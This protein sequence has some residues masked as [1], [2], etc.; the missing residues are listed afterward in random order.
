MFG[1]L[2]LKKVV[3]L[4][5]QTLYQ[6][7]WF[8]LFHQGSKCSVSSSSQSP[9]IASWRRAL[10]WT[11][12][13]E[14]NQQIAAMLVSSIET[15]VVQNFNNYVKNHF[16]TNEIALIAVLRCST[17]MLNSTLDIKQKHILANSPPHSTRRTTTN[18][19]ELVAWA[20]KPWPATSALHRKCWRHREN[21]ESCPY[22]Y[23][24]HL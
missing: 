8:C 14:K 19:S 15:T 18:G 22:H 4:G 1:G 20:R 17:T 3:A 13:R 5:D 24:Y 2:N 9:S 12:P 10:G 21:S 7:L 16:N 23:G 11:W 6:T